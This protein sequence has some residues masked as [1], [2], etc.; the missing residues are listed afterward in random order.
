M[1]CIGSSMPTAFRTSGIEIAGGLSTNP[2][3]CMMA[4]RIPNARIAW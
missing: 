2:Q 4:F 3:I 1:H